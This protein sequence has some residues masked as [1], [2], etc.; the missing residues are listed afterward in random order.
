MVQTV[1]GWVGGWG[2]VWGG[3]AL[4]PPPNEKLCAMQQ[5]AHHSMQVRRT[6]MRPLHQGPQRREDLD[7]A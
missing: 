6:H 1:G 3:G 4:D 2:G 7:G 5:N